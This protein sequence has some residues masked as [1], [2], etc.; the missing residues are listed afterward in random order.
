MRFGILLMLAIICGSSCKTQ[1]KVDRPSVDKS[2][3][4]D[5]KM[6]FTK[7]VDLTEAIEIAEKKNKPLFVEFEADWCLPCKVL[8]DEVFTHQETADFFNKNFVNYKLDI[9]TVSGAN[10][11]ML[12][13]VNILPTL[14]FVDHK[15]RTL[16]RNDGSLMHDGLINLAH[17]ALSN[18]EVGSVDQ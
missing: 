9:E 16:S 10:M 18:W 8:S 11:K 1:K 5:G 15:G 17:E 4:L 3:Y 14:I 13:G 6:V 2:T 12:Y 7:A